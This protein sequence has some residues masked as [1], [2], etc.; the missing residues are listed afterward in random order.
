VKRALGVAVKRADKEVKARTRGER[1]DHREIG[2]KE[3]QDYDKGGI[4]GQEV[5]AG[6][7]RAVSS[8]R[9]RADGGGGR[10]CSGRLRESLRRFDSI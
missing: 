9:G 3:A 10:G 6:V 2:E 8:A 5:G 7:A 4:R 1:R